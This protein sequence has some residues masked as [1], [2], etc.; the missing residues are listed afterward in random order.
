M[1]AMCFQFSMVFDAWTIRKQGL[2]KWATTTVENWLNHCT[3]KFLMDGWL[4]V[5]SE[6]D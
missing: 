4:L 5:I 3:Q 1:D 2:G 6:P